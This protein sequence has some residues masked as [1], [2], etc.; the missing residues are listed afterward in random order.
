MKR[1]LVFAIV[2]SSLFSLCACGSTEIVEK[3]V[4]VEVPVIPEQYVKYQDL[5]DELEAGNY[6]AA[7]ARIEKMKPVPETPPIIEVQITRDNFLDYFEFIEFNE[8]FIHYEKDSSGKTKLVLC[9][10]GF[11]LK[12]KYRFAEE[13]ENECSIELGIKYNVLYFYPNNRAILCNLDDCTYEITGKPDRTDSED[14][15]LKGRYYGGEISTYGITNN[16]AS[17]LSS[18][19]SDQAAVVDKQTIEIVSASGMIYLYGE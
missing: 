17:S 18:N 2:L 19:Y 6:E 7:Q 16:V 13:K 12:S 14:T 15:I 10:P 1:I 11:F 5:L 9:T 3:E 4:K 8:S